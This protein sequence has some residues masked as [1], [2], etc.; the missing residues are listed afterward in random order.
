MLVLDN[1]LL[2]D[3]LNGTPEA[4]AFLEGHESEE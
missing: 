4:A 2:S 1:D 3:F